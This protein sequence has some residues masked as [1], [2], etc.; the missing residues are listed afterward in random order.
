[1]VRLNSV[2]GGGA[3][4]PSKTISNQS[5]EWLEVDL[6]RQYTVTGVITQGR[7]DRG[8]GQEFAQHVMIQYWEEEE[9][10]WRSAGGRKEANID[11]FT[12]VVIPLR[13]PVITNRVRIV[14]V[15]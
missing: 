8:V 7:W 9:G 5:K 3:W 11:T 4:C 2:A 15:S 12:P 14:L 1:M 10:E 6:G 13:I